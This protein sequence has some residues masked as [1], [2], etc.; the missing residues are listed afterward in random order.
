[1]PEPF[2]SKTGFGM[3]VV[4]KPFTRAVCFTTYLYSI[5]WSDSLSRSLNFMSISAWPPDATSWCCASTSM[6]NFCMLST[7][8][9]RRSWK[10]STGGAGK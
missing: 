3:N 9:V 4:V 6:P 2:A 1:M 10:W 5:S 7:I 8:S